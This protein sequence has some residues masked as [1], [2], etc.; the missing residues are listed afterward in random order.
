MW[1]YKYVGLQVCG[2]TSMWGY[3]YVGLQVCGVTSMWGYK[4]WLN[5]E[6]VPDAPHSTQYNVIQLNHITVPQ[7]NGSLTSDQGN[8]GIDK[9]H[10]AHRRTLPLSN[11]KNYICKVH[12]STF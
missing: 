1:G 10:R 11:L 5:Q 7:N 12:L 9:L 8:T 4:S 6:P 2:V 3:K